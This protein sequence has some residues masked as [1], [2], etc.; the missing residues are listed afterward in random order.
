MFSARDRY[1]TRRSDCRQ[2][3]AASYICRTTPK[4][5]CPF[6]IVLI[7]LLRSHLPESLHT[8]W[9]LSSQSL[10]RVKIFGCGLSLRASSISLSVSSAFG[11]FSPVRSHGLKLDGPNTRTTSAKLIPLTVDVVI[12]CRRYAFF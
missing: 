7:F 2:D 6:P 9:F 5:A 4:A 12:S 10:I 8:A 3:K 11:H 1:E